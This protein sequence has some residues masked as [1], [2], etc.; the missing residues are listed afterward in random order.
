M[1]EISVIL[2]YFPD[3]HTKFHCGGVVTIILNMCIFCLKIPFK[4]VYT[5]ITCTFNHQLVQKHTTLYVKKIRLRFFPS[6]VSYV[7]EVE[8]QEKSLARRNV[9]YCWQ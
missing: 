5:K 8:L 4:Q 9:L 1:S 2:N 3:S 7:E 6:S